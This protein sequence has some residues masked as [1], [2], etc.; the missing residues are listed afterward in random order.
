MFERAKVQDSFERTP[1]SS[2]TRPVRI[3]AVAG[4]VQLE[5]E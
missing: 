5:V 4:Q 3:E 1:C 2:G